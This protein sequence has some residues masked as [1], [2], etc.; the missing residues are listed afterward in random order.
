MDKLEKL[1]VILP[2]M[3]LLALFANKM[4]LLNFKGRYE[5]RVEANWPCTLKPP[6]DGCK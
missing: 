3:A 1:L 5:A 2:L 4:G 6:V